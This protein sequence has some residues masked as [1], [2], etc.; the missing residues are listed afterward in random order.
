METL[1]RIAEALLQPEVDRHFRGVQLREGDRGNG[2]PQGHRRGAEPL[3][4][5]DDRLSVDCYSHGTSLAWTWQLQPQQPPKD[6]HARVEMAVATDEDSTDS[7]EKVSMTKEYETTDA[8]DEDYDSS[9]DDDDYMEQED[10]ENSPTD[11]RQEYHN[12]NN[13]SNNSKSRYW[14][15]PNWTPTDRAGNPV[16][17]ETIRQQL[18]H[19]LKNTPVTKTIFLQLLGVNA[20]SFNKFS[21][22]HEYVGD[23]N[24]RAKLNSTYLNGARFVSS[25]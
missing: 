5:D 6:D 7:D 12:N 2:Y 21:R 11:K 24:E 20:N 8:S 19:F 17:P 18:L 3:G 13:N 23:Y 22:P 4:P 25:G 1:T 15:S 9:D 16:P 14:L 10:K